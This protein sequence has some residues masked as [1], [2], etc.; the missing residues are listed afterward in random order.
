MDG[1]LMKNL[2]ECECD[3][4]E[5]SK[6]VRRHKNLGCV[7]QQQFCFSSFDS[8]RGARVCQVAS[9]FSFLE[10]FCEFLPARNPSGPKPHLDSRRTEL[11]PNGMWPFAKFW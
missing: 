8:K 3:D 1:E 10:H 6:S 4:R 5:M 2:R 9:G 11:L 7:N